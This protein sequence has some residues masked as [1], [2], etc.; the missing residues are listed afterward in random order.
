VET[1]KKLEMEI[2]CEILENGRTL[3]RAILHEGWCII[4]GLACQLDFSI[5]ILRLYLF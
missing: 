3:A 5:S 1:K 2:E 4:V